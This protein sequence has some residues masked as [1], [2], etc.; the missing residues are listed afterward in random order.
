MPR[1]KQFLG[2]QIG[3]KLPFAT[4][5]RL[6]RESKISGKT[7]AQI[8]REALEFMWNVQDTQASSGERKPQ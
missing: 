1:D 6:R 8:V 2:S 7:I 5:V 4:D 3:A